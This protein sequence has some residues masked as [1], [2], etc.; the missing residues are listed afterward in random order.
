VTESVTPHDL[1][2]ELTEQLATCRLVCEVGLE[3]ELY[4]R[5]VRAMANLV[6]E[7]NY[8]INRL[9]RTSPA[10]LTAYLVAEGIHSYEAGT[11]WG[12]LSI[13]RLRAYQ[14]SL[15]PQFEEALST[16]DLEDF[17]ELLEEE[18]ATRY[19]SRILIHGG[20]PRYS[21]RDFFTILLH[22]LKGGST[23]ATDLVAVWRSRKT[24]FQ[25][26]DKPVERFLLRGGEVALDLLDRCVEMVLDEA[27][28]NAVPSAEE[29]GLPTYIVRAYEMMPVAERRSARTGPAIPR[30]RV[31]L[32]PWDPFGPRMHLPAVPE[33]FREAE[34]QVNDGVRVTSVP[35]R[36]DRAERA[37]LQPAF[38]WNVGLWQGYE[39]V[40]ELTF[41]ALEETPIMLFDPDS[42]RL[43]A[44]RH[45]VRLESVWAL[46]P[47]A[48]VSLTTDRDGLSPIHVQEEF[49]DLAGAWHG[50]AR[51]HYDLSG[52]PTVF[53]Q[54]DGSE[55]RMI[56]VVVPSHRPR[57][58]AEPVGGV[59]T[60]EGHPVFAAP[61]YLEVPLG[62]ASA[63]NWRLNVRSGKDSVQTSL[64][65][66][67]DAGG[68][69]YDLG[70]VLSGRGVG[71]FGMTL[72]GP[73]GSDLREEFAVIPELSLDRPSRPLLPADGVV[74][75]HLAA[76]GSGKSGMWEAMLEFAEEADEAI[77]SFPIDDQSEVSLRVTIPK[78]LWSIDR[79][80]DPRSLFGNRTLRTATEDVHEGIASALSVRT[81]LPGVP[82]TLALTDGAHL[83]QTSGTETTSGIEGRWTFELAPFTATL[84][85]SAAPVLSFELS[86]AQRRQVVA[87]VLTRLVVLNLAATSQLH[88]ASGADVHLTF[89]ENRPLRG[90]V[91]RLWPLDRPWSDPATMPIPDDVEGTALLPNVV[92][93][94]YL[95][96]IAIED[97][98]I[99]SSRPPLWSANT[100]IVT[101]GDADEIAVY[102][103]AL[104]LASPLSVLEAAI[105]SNRPLR[106]LTSDEVRRI[107]PA[108]TEVLSL[109]LEER[110]HRALTMRAFARVAD[111]LLDTPDAFVEALAAPGTS[112]VLALKAGICFLRRIRKTAPHLDEAVIRAL[113]STCP[114]LAAALDCPQAWANDAAA[115]RSEEALG[116]PAQDEHAQV[117]PGGPVPLPF[118]QM[119]REQMSV[120][121]RDMN[122]VPK[123]WL[124]AD[125]LAS[126]YLDWLDERCDHEDAVDAW[127][128]DYESLLEAREL[129]RPFREAIAMR[130]P[131]PQAPRWF[132]F[133]QMTL[134]ACLHLVHGSNQAEHA[135]GALVDAVVYAQRLVTRDL[136]LA[137][138][139]DVA[140]ERRADQ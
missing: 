11:Y 20:I 40:R 44:S 27:R 14:G 46:H 21:L 7:G 6:A 9:S 70:A 73:L 113:W 103:A 62:G 66:L 81:R 32:D 116:W 93:G 119:G 140:W 51:R 86:V 1:D 111:L 4:R 45:V 26:I 107:A 12:K 122:L 18:H 105:V 106:S 31:E 24:R 16:L 36:L 3:G 138:V 120:L 87:R 95:A 28:T 118:E 88:G 65:L 126:T 110:C 127:C 55:A 52:V 25:G 74:K 114:P 128:R 42:G 19:V 104:D 78:V 39:R 37:M 134:S 84:R 2:R 38:A 22:A 79:S 99:P 115:A 139:L 100:Q 57:L 71:V 83:L 35:A 10:L 135:A 90:R 102:A 136:L 133:P 117:L 137:C 30:P 97:E 91:A 61:P 77:T 53:L 112:P 41:E 13:P 23:E 92:V 80:D 48:T 50:Y 63:S 8:A 56:R 131:A 96:D 29:L 72:R 123:R 132:G 49:P 76:P 125:S 54:E 94:R 64:D 67:P 109:L 121:R 101:I 47:K 33:E 43:V 58:I 15:G 17:D 89:E 82:V 68:G 59:T 75:V 69:V 98:W 130:R 60:V 129:P 108:G 124:D 5:I 34:W 85:A